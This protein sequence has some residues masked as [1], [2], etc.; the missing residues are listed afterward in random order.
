MFVEADGTLW[1]QPTSIL[2]DNLRVCLETNREYQEQY[3]GVRDQL[4][5]NSKN[6][7]FDF[8]ENLI[9]GKFDLFCRR[10]EKLIDMFSTV[11]QFSGLSKHNLE[12]MDNL[13]GNFFNIVSDFKRKPC[14]HVPRSMRH[15]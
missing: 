15:A 11:E 10:V 7:Q 12:G 13:M 1:E 3:R 6:K 4:A 9:F 14:V 2:I 5:Q 8:S